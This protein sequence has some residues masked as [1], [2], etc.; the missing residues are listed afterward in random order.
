MQFSASSLIKANRRS[1]RVSRQSKIHQEDSGSAWK[2]D[3]ATNG[4]KS[5]SNLQK[6]NLQ[7]EDHD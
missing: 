4:R 6:A 2:D 7:E 1:L 5:D 3:E